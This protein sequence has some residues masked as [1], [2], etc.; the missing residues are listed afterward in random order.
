MISDFYV[1]H[2]TGAPEPDGRG[3]CPPGGGGAS[4]HPPWKRLR[5]EC[6]VVRRRPLRKRGA[7]QTAGAP[8]TGKCRSNS[9]ER[10]G[11]SLSSNTP[12]LCVTH[13]RGFYSTRLSRG[14]SSC[15]S[16]TF[17]R[18]TGRVYGVS[19]RFAPPLQEGASAGAHSCGV[20]VDLACPRRRRAS[21]CTDTTHVGGRNPAR[22]RLDA[23][24]TS[25]ARRSPGVA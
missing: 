24:Q 15:F 25:H 20:S 10:V 17:G 2:C 21:A 5:G 4:G 19:L 22:L 7:H 9:D 12:R 14:V 13:R 11:K 8:R 18:A 6:A 16:A 1:P 23:G 3:P